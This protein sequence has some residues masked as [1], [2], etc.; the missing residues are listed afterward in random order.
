M[1]LRETNTTG[2]L[3]ST[4]GNRC[5]A[6][7]LAEL[8]LSG[9]GLKGSITD[10]PAFISGCGTLS[11]LNL[12]GNHIGFWP[13]GF[14]HNHNQSLNVEVLDLS[15]N[16]VVGSLGLEWIL[17]VG[18]GVL[19]HLYLT[20]NRIS[21]KLSPIGNCSAL[22][23]LDLSSN[24]L[25]D[26]S[27]SAVFAECDNLQFLNLSSNSFSGKLPKNMFGSCRSLL[28][29][30]LSFNNFSGTIPEDFGSCWSL[31]TLTLSSNNFSGELPLNTFSSLPNLK[32]LELGYNRMNGELSHLFFLKLSELEV[33]DLSSNALTGVIPPDLCNSGRSGSGLHG[34][35]ELYLQNNQFTGP[36][37]RS[38]SECSKLESLDLSFNY[39]NGG[40]SGSIGLL[41]HLQSLIMWQNLLV[42]EIPDE[43]GKL[44]NLEN[45]ILDNNNLTGHIPDLRNCTNLNW[46]SLSSNRLTG[47]IPSWIGSM[48]N[49]AIL[50]IGNNSL[51]GPIP[52]EIGNCKSLVW[53]DLNSNMLNG[54]IPRTIAKQSGNIAVGL[55]K[56]KKYVYLR[57]DGSSECHGSGNLL[58]FAGIRQEE[59]DRIPTRQSCNFTRV[60]M[61]STSYTFNNNG[62][63]IFVDLSYNRLQGDIPKEFGDMFYV[64]IINLGHNALSGPIPPE[65]GKLGILGIL[66]LSHNSLEG[67]I[68][69]SLSGLAMLAELDLSYNNLS[70][71]IPDVG[72]FATFPPYRYAHNP[73]LCGFPLPKCS[74]NSSSAVVQHQRSRQKRTSPA[75]SVAMGLLFSLFCIFGLLMIVMESRRRQKKRRVRKENSNSV[76]GGGDSGGR[77]R[78]YMGSGN[79]GWK[80]TSAREAMSINLATFE[81]PLR[82]LTF[83]DLLEATNGFHDDSL[84]GSGGFGDVYKAQLKDGSVVA[85]KKL[86]HV[87]GQG[88]REFTAEMETI[89]RVKHRNL[90]PLLGYCKV[91][92][93]RLLVYEY[94]KYGSLEDVLHN[95]RKGGVKLNWVC[96]RRIAMGAARGLAFLHHNCTP[97]II[98]RDMKS[99]N[100]LLDNSLEAR[101][102]D[103]GMARMM[104][105]MDTHL[106]VSTLAGTPG[107]V[108][109]EYYQSFRCSTKGDVYSYGVVLLELLTG[110]Q[111]TDSADFGD[112]NLVGW[113]KQ[114]TKLRITD[115]FD[116][117]LLEEDPGLELELL[118]HLKIACVCLDDRP[119]RRPTMLKVMSMFNESQVDSPSSPPTTTELSLSESK[120]ERE[121][122]A[123]VYS[124]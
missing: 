14:N 57:N 41:S 5:A 61:G 101:V 11:F 51:S 110:R 124:V 23:S 96:R 113:V 115:V 87:S 71:Q 73:S 88:D 45:L 24:N 117:E 107:Y 48:P 31:T 17:H 81:N 54:S 95:R 30:D 2:F 102:S 79:S 4:Q 120:E 20:G 59:I 37:P 56:G 35:R 38:I 34:I 69:Q 80:L 103:F 68:P 15:Y 91:G 75:R 64:F 49:L 123:L 44:E 18:S 106:S 29:L 70:G 65:F 28:R 121:S 67:P 89:G 108:P 82:N 40:I 7:G 105:A 3:S 6:S 60:Y 98:H 8:D 1:S 66:D 19:R 78:Y 90:V 26:V 85:I 84:I 27:S 10:I 16:S 22:E 93:E 62:S 114:H 77:D 86:I 52:E 111:P 55:V 119:M 43:L 46:I 116:K 47:F 58:E 92:E 42:G 13:Q 94:M 25:S 12:S 97:H 109:P 118:E 53:L 9:N 74:L 32:K 36:I 50:K 33:L 39:L 63:M 100:V 83:A 72:Q 122:D 104:S 76:G 99:S 21:G 112:N